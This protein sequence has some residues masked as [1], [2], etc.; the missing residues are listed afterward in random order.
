MDP[1]AIGPVTADDVDTVVHDTIAALWTVAEQDWHVPAGELDWDCWE[2]LEHAADD[3]FAYAGQL[4]P[5]TP[6]ATADVPFAL[7]QQRAGGPRSTIFAQ[8]EGGNAG[9][10]QVFET[11]G[12]FLSAAVRTAAPQTLAHHIFG[13]ADPAGF[14]AMGVIEVLV[15][16]H[17]VAGGLGFAW[18]PDEGVCQRALARLFP[19]APTEVAPWQALLWST[20]R[21]ALPNR[22]RLTRWRWYSAPAPS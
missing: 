22:T 9:L 1:Q 13:A 3:L 12:G 6:P 21:T 2:T 14:A 7:R 11:C 4:L 17:D 15:H 16:L 20:G 8:P 18:L 5:H 19:D 10:I